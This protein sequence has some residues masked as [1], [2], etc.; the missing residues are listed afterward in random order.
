MVM[1]CWCILFQLHPIAFLAADIRSEVYF[2]LFACKFSFDHK[3]QLSLSLG[4]FH[5]E[6]FLG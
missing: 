3:C 6:V 5:L 1:Q 4:S 2:G